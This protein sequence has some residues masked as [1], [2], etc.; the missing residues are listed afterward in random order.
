MQDFFHPQYIYIQCIYSVY[1]YTVYIYNYILYYIYVKPKEGPIHPIQSIP[2]DRDSSTGV[3]GVQH[4]VVVK[5]HL[6]EA[7]G[8]H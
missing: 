3:A 4:F 7:F 5:N 2:S 8:G 1:I 6:H